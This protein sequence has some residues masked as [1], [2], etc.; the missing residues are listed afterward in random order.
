M[1]FTINATD[2]LDS[3]GQELD[4]NGDGQPSGNYVAILTK[5]GVISMP[6]PLAKPSE[7]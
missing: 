2:A 5:A 3:H 1:Q 7:N 4:G 6:R